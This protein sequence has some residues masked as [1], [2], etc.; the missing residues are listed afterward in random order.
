MGLARLSRG[1][2]AETE[3]RA[4]ARLVA[5]AFG[6]P[7]RRAGAPFSGSW[8]SRAR[9]PPRRADVRAVRQRSVGPG[10]AGPGRSPAGLPARAHRQQHPGALPRVRGGTWRRRP[11][12]ARRR[13]RSAVHEHLEHCTSCHALA[14]EL[15]EVNSRLGAILTPAALAGAAAALVPGASGGHG[16]AGAAKAGAAAGANPVAADQAGR[17][18]G[19]RP[20]PGSRAAAVREGARVWLGAHWRLLRLHSLTIAAGT[21]AGWPRRGAWSSPSASRGQARLP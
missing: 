4:E 19:S 14:T 21:A 17:P 16:T 12:P 3:A 10:R 20:G 5:A 8:R 1:P 2:E 9:H 18:A 15:T 7:A 13:R 6:A 11:R